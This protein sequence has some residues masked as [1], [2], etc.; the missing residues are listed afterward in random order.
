MLTA[1]LTTFAHEFVH[2]IKSRIPTSILHT[3]LLICFQN[4][5]VFL[6]KVNTQCLHT[7]NFICIIYLYCVKNGL[8]SVGGCGESFQIIADELRQTLLTSVKHKKA[9]KWTS[10]SSS[11][12]PRGTPGGAGWRLFGTHPQI[13]ADMKVASSVKT[14][15]YARKL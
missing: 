4:F 15:N 10:S 9:N 2:H 12:Y 1:W 13:E 3:M 14:D 8:I 11:W 7:F 5:L 6:R